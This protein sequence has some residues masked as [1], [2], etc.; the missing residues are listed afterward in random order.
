MSAL[1]GVSLRSRARP[2]AG[3]AEWTRGQGRGTRRWRVSVAR[4]S[5]AARSGAT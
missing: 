2:Q 4:E 1:A 3:N 5:W